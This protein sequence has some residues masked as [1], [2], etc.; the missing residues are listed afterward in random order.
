MEGRTEWRIALASTR[1][2]GEDVSAT[3]VL[4]PPGE[5][6]FRAK[7]TEGGRRL[8]VLFRREF[9]AWRL[10][11]AALGGVHPPNAESEQA[12]DAR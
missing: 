4:S 10:R 9:G 1:R 6:P 5:D 11:A 8:R 3:F 12:R 7:K 2:E